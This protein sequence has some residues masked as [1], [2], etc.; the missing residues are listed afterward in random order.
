MRHGTL[1]TT[2]ISIPKARMFW[3]AVAVLALVAAG[4][5]TQVR[6]A[7]A[8][9]RELAPLP[10]SSAATA[11]AA[12][13][14][15]GECAIFGAANKSDRDCVTLSMKGR[16]SRA[17]GQKVVVKGKI[18]MKK[19]QRSTG[20]KVKR[21]VILQRAKDGTRWTDEQRRWKKVGSARIKKR[22]SWS[23]KTRIKLNKR[24]L[25]TLRAV[26]VP[27]KRLLLP[28]SGRVSK[29][30]ASN[31]VTSESDATTAGAPGYVYTVKNNS[32][33]ELRLQAVA[34]ANGSST[35]A[36]P[37]NFDENMAVAMIVAGP[38]SGTSLGFNLIQKNPIAGEPSVY[39]FYGG[40]NDG[41]ACKDMSA[42]Q[43]AD[44][45]AVSV[46]IDNAGFWGVGYTGTMTWPGGESCNFRMLTQ[47]EKSLVDQPTWAKVLEIVGGVIVVCAA[48]YFAG[49]ALLAAGG[50][51]GGELLVSEGSIA[52]EES[53]TSEA[54]E[55]LDNLVRDRANGG[56]RLIPLDELPPEYSEDEVLD[57]NLRNYSLG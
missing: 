19:L 44:G 29:S 11:E 50:E 15:K 55:A 5:T 36:N 43:V 21:K 34:N 37:S 38:P 54:Q 14:S 39:T 8:D 57:A 56:W 16:S 4:L 26:A 1:V 45:E 2:G 53:L 23:Y 9:S 18:R 32:S 13:T 10:A 3:S 30:A 40:S 31:S 51:A 27:K 52:S 42:P 41:N 6:P 33:H 47:T 48:I 22:K 20:A 17:V 28:A 25:H 46:E 7:N 35:V 12:A 24:G 49:A